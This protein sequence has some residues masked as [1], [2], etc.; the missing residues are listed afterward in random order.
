MG[1]MIAII[2]GTLDRLPHRGAKTAEHER[3]YGPWPENPEA[4]FAQILARAD[5]AFP[6]H[7][8]IALSQAHEIAARYGGRKD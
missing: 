6:D 3:E 1:G 4:L 8:D 2:R 5:A 7:P